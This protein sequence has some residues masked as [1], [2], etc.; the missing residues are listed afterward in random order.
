MWIIL[1]VYFLLFFS[2]SPWINVIVLQWRRRRRVHD[3]F[4]CKWC[5]FYYSR[6]DWLTESPTRWYKDYKT[7]AQNRYFCYLRDES[8]AQVSDYEPLT[9]EQFLPFSWL[10]LTCCATAV[11][12]LIGEIV[13]FY[14]HSHATYAEK[15]WRKDGKVDDDDDDYFCCCCKYWRF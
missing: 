5:C 14:V 7:I 13:A 10:L 11:V 1:G 9:M 4:I 3:S 15:G 8:R 2:P 12:A 6:I